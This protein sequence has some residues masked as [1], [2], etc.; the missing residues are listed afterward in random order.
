MQ[1]FLKILLFLCV[2]IPCIAD[3]GEQA[4]HFEFYKGY[5]ELTCLDYHIKITAEQRAS[6]NEVLIIVIPREQG[7]HFNIRNVQFATR[8]PNIHLEGPVAKVHGTLT[9]QYSMTHPLHVP[10]TVPVQVAIVNEFTVSANEALIQGNNHFEKKLPK[11][12]T[13]GVNE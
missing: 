3:E 11:L 13:E 10:M 6:D 2:W 7:V 5:T 1:F 12:L 4:H 8:H 9:A